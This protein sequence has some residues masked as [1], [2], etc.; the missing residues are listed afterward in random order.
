MQTIT[1]DHSGKVLIHENGRVR[2]MSER[3]MLRQKFILRAS[4][5]PVTCSEF[6]REWYNYVDEMRA[7][8]T[9]LREAGE[10]F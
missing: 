2:E 7:L 1:T 9:Q 3:E 8:E 10:V 4:N 6:S 5:P